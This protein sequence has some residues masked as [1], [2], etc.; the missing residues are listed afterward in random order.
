MV[1]DEELGNWWC[2]KAENAWERLKCL[3]GKFRGWKCLGGY[4]ESMSKI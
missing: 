2:V 4:Y 3:G 1:K